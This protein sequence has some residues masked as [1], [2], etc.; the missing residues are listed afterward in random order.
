MTVSEL[1]KAL[2]HVPDDLLVLHTNIYHDMTVAE[3][4][5]RARVFKSS[6]DGDYSRFPADRCDTDVFL[7]D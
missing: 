3:D 6:Q 2:E 7:I 4:A 5:S 1:K